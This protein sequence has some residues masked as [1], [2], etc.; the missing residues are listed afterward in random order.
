MKLLRNHV[1]A[2]RTTQCLFYI[3]RF[4]A[5]TALDADTKKDENKEEVIDVAVK[6]D[7]MEEVLKI[8]KLRSKLRKSEVSISEKYLIV[9]KVSQKS[10]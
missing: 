8:P 2:S 4:F 10:K 3:S 7:V 1:F 6:E 9:L 5:T